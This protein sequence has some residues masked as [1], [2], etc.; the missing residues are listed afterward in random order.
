VNGWN[1]RESRQVS[2]LVMPDRLFVDLDDGI[3]N[4]P[5]VRSSHVT[6]PC[7]ILKNSREIGDLTPQWID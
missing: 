7:N 1:I 5:M 4:D 2:D 3:D 6:V